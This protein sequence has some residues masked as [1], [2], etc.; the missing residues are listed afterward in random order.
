MCDVHVRTQ[1]PAALATRGAL[2]LV[3]HR[4]SQ[5]YTSVYKCAHWQEVSVCCIHTGLYWEDNNSP[6]SA[7]VT[8]QQLAGLSCSQTKQRINFS[9]SIQG[10]EREAVVDKI[11]DC[12]GIILRKVLE[13]KQKHPLSFHRI[14]LSHRGKP[15]ASGAAACC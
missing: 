12:C 11:T 8:C 2:A 10:R 4:E 1:V 14:H 7:R 13:G 9:F 3:Q 15:A 5:L 6:C